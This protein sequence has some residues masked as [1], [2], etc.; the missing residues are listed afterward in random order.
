MMRNSLNNNLDDKYLP[1]ISRFFEPT[2]IRSFCKTFQHR[3]RVRST[4]T[5][6]PR[7]P[8][9]ISCYLRL[10]RSN[11]PTSEV[12]SRHLVLRVKCSRTLDSTSCI[13]LDLQLDSWWRG[14]VCVGGAV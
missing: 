5:V 7:C 1:R 2:L 4:L 8:G 6:V 14:C 3:V 10:N 13:T 9:G 12:L 11:I